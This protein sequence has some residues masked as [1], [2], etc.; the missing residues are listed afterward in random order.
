MDL[1]VG[2]RGRLTAL[3]MIF[4]VL[5]VLVRY[6]IHPLFERY[7]KVSDDITTLQDEIGHYRRII[8]QLPDLKA[9]TARVERNQPLAP[10]LISGSNE[11]LAVA[12]LQ[13]RLKESARGGS[14][15]ARRLL[16]ARADG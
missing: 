12:N 11:S 4:I 13:K 14:R 5:I 3:T 9:E 15:H 8:A 6:G 2:M 16:C 10:F 7:T 1:P